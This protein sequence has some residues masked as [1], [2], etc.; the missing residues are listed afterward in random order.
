MTLTKELDSVPT[1][2]PSVSCNSKEKALSMDAESAEFKNSTY[3]QSG[4]E[5][6]PILDT[7]LD[8]EEFLKIDFVEEEVFRQTPTLSIASLPVVSLSGESIPRD[9]EKEGQDFVIPQK[10]NLSSRLAG[11]LKRGDTSTLSK[12]DYLMV[13]AT[14]FIALIAKGNSAGLSVLTVEWLQQFDKSKALILYVPALNFAITSAAG[15]IDGMLINRFGIFRIILLGCFLQVLCMIASSFSTNAITLVIVLGFF[16]GL[17]NCF[18]F[19]NAFI[20]IGVHF[21]EVA[22]PIIAF[23]SVAGP[24]GGLIF[25]NLIAVIIELYGWRGCMFILAGINLQVVPLAIFLTFAQKEAKIP[26]NSEVEAK[27]NPEESQ[28]LLDLSVLKNFLFVMYI[29]SVGLT[30][31]GINTVFSMLPDFLYEKGLNL[32]GAANI[33][34]LYY[35]LSAVPRYDNAEKKLFFFYLYN[36]LLKKFIYVSSLFTAYM[37]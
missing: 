27:R 23:I 31:G 25:P 16:A 26:Q 9:E 19:V 10:L 24:I 13:L 18:L 3:L 32:K 6:D 28:K 5:D 8:S 29:F 11:L 21:G 20:F 33:Y 34:A 37:P 22:K 2:S 35:I 4:S 30:V 7:Q 12:R 14:F 15:I 36:L 1:V 17:G